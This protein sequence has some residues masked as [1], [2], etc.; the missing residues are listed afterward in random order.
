[1]EVIVGTS[2]GFVYVLDARGKTRRG[3][4]VQVGEVQA[5]VAVEDLRQ[6]DGG[7]LELVRKKRR[8]IREGRREEKE[9]REYF[10]IVSRIILTRRRILPSLSLHPP[11]HTQGGRGWPR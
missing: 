10:D 8:E 4:P 1:M 7:D 2:L 11:L 3:F 9:R 6:G 5:Q